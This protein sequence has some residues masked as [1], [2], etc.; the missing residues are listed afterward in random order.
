MTWDTRSLLHHDQG[1]RANKC[2]TLR[3]FC[4]G[5]SI[6]ALHELHG[7]KEELNSQLYLRRVDMAVLASIPEHAAGGVAFIFPEMTRQQMEEGIENERIRDS[8]I[9]PGR[10]QGLAIKARDNQ[11]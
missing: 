5:M 10:V 9:Y 1:L 7:T 6:V 11:D 3:E 2:N 4:K 8:D